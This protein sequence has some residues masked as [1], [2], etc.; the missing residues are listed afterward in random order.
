MAKSGLVSSIGFLFLVLLSWPSASAAADLPVLV[1]DTCTEI[2]ASVGVEPKRVALV[3]GNSAYT[4][5]IPALRNPG[6]DANGVV[7]AL[8]KLGFS[9][10]ALADGTGSVMRDCIA[11]AKTAISEDAIAIIYYSGH[12]IQVDDRNYMIATDAAADGA[13]S[14]AYIYIDDIIDAVK[15]NAAS[16]MVFLDACR[17]NPFAPE[18]AEGLS[19]STG[20][21]LERGLKKVSSNDTQ[22]RQQ[23]KGIFVAYSTSP[24]AIAT[25]GTGSMSP[26]TEAFVASVGKPGYSVQRALSE[27]SK[28]V[29]EATDWSQTPWIKSSL[30]AEIML[31]GGLTEEQALTL[32]DKHAGESHR[33]LSSGDVPGAISEA[34]KGLPLPLPA[35]AETRF[36]KAHLA[37]VAATRSTS[38]RLGPTEGGWAPSGYSPITNRVVGSAWGEVRTLSLWDTGK[39][40]KIA[41]LASINQN[42]P[43]FN[44]SLSPDGQ[45][46]VAH[47]SPG[48]VIVVDALSGVTLRTITLPGV[49]DSNNQ[50]ASLHFGPDS[51][52][53]VALTSH[54]KDFAYQSAV[55]VWDTETGQQ[56]KSFAFKDIFA[57]NSALSQNG[58]YAAD[59]N[60]DLR[61]SAIAFLCTFNTTRIDGKEP[62]VMIFGKIDLHSGTLVSYGQLPTGGQEQLGDFRFRDDANRI[63]AQHY[64]DGIYNRVLLN[65]ETGKLVGERVPAIMF[66]TSYSPDGSRFFGGDGNRIEF[67]SADTG[68]HVGGL[69]GNTGG[70]IYPA[71]F[72][73]NGQLL[74]QQRETGDVWWV[75]PKGADLVAA[76]L[77]RLDDAGRSSAMAQSLAFKVLD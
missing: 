7:S 54:L 38:Y 28:S 14:D 39:G 16:V 69:D 35:D 44:A 13:L 18:G 77:A 66:S 73:A 57:G 12:G 74:G 53:L 64:T 43:D 61:V 30:T 60:V 41:D 1:A 20:R 3:I 17:N 23:A 36:A 42:S 19:V 27:V 62:M 72:T 37:L 33:L 29:G 32:S 10:F 8:Y 24:N 65:T 21:S 55:Q 50:L 45:R 70:F 56:R 2:P 25:D 22:A 9:I 49:G 71:V 5:G 40:I 59:A 48:Q 47:V 15:E 26:F 68:E 51:R 6:N 11:R 31:N 58:C 46:I 34:L 63:V 76:A 4:G 52:T 67:Y 75:P